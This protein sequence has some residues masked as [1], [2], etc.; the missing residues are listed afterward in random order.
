MK[1]KQFITY[2]FL[3]V[4]LFL[5]ACQSEI[6]MGD[7][8]GT[9]TPQEDGLG[10]LSVAVNLG[11]NRTRSAEDWGTVYENKVKKI[12]L[13]LYN[14]NQVKY[15]F[16]FDIESTVNGNSITYQNPDGMNNLYQSNDRDQFITYARGV[17]PANYQMLVIINPAERSNIYEITE[18]GQPLSLLYE[19]VKISAEELY[20]EEENEP[21]AFMMTN[22][23][24][25]VYIPENSLKSSVNAAN[26]NPVPIEVSR[27]VAKVTLDT[28][29]MY[30]SGG[31]VYNL[32]WDLDITNKYTYW[33]RKMTYAFSPYTYDGR[34]YERDDTPREYLYAED[35]NFQRYSDQNWGSPEKRQEAFNIFSITGNSPSFTAPT[36]APRYCLENTMSTED[37]YPSVITRV[38]IRC[39]FAPYGFGEGE[40]YYIFGNRVL[41]QNQMSTYINVPGTIPPDLNGLSEAI[42]I[43]QNEGF[44]LENPTASFESESGIKYYQNGIN[45]YAIMI[46]HFEEASLER[47]YGYYGVVRNN[48]YWVELTSIRGIGSPTE[49]VGEDGY[50]AIYF[51][52]L[53]WKDREQE[54]ILQ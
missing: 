37:Q 30:I 16:D 24:D 38:L 42:W 7:Q 3:I 41:R 14:E 48:H 9:N 13:V 39:N 4:C 1:Q 50:L 10:Y 20:T 12:R 44:N 53:R 5:T 54:N 8:E 33:M 40:S 2:C 19:S 34:D 46:R 17:A 51:Q 31:G 28:S 29:R 32:T 45:Y 36:E 22:H 21:S 49:E 26:T 25:L 43:A 18:T 52:I 27:V 15:A 23:K 47:S 35:P 6:L 11:D